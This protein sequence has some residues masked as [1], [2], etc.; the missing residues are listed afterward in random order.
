MSIQKAYQIFD[1]DGDGFITFTEFNKGLDTWVTLSFLA[2]QALFNYLDVLNIGMF[3]YKRWENVLKR[4][5]M[6]TGK[7][8]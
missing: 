5:V 2:K 7:N 6:E 8:Y 4:F 3:D 1:E